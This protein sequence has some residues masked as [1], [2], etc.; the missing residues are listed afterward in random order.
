MAKKSE[1]SISDVVVPTLRIMEKGDYAPN[2][3]IVSDMDSNG[4]PHTARNT[5]VDLLR[6]CF[7]FHLAGDQHLGTT[8]HYGIDDWKDGGVAVC[9]PS[10]SN[11]YPRRW[12]PNIEGKNRNEGAP[13]YAGDFID[14]FNNYLTVYA[15]SNP[16]FTG[17]KP[18]KLYDRSAGYGIIKFNKTSRDIAIE[19]WPRDG[20]P[21]DPD[22][23]P[24]EDWPVKINQLDNYGRQAF[25]YLPKI[26][27]EG[28][29]QPPVIKVID[30]IGEEVY[31]I[32]ATGNEFD[33]KVFA[34]GIYKVVVGEPDKDNIKII[35]NLRPSN[36]RQDAVVVK[37]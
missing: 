21:T 14:G 1:K 17:K 32:R 5:A 4:W 12:F 11:Y 34:E 13:K 16:V 24:Y 8:I 6:K 27:T 23:K 35:E 33:P 37:F 26:V 7:A 19:L 22:S 36:E 15:V 29:T 31:T 10:I 3:V 9:V 25:G 28:L 18:S 30:G 2:D 20:D